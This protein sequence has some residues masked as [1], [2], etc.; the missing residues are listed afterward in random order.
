MKAAPIWLACA[1]ATCGITNA[2]VASNGFINLAVRDRTVTGSIEIAVRDAELAVG[3][4][5]NNDGRVTW[6]ELRHAAPALAQYVQ[7]HFR[8]SA[9]SSACNVQAGALQVNRRVDGPYAWL[10]LEARCPREVR[11]I[12]L[13]YDLLRDVDPSHRGLLTLTSGTTVQTAVLGAVGPVTLEIGRTSRGRAIRE[14]FQE[15]VWHIWRGYDHLLFLVSL[16]LPAVLLRRQKRWEAVDAAYPAF[17]SIL[18]VVTAFTLAHSV[19]LSLAAFGVVRLPSRLTESVIAASI[20]LAAL[21]NI[22]P[23]VTDARARIAFGF[24]LLHGFGFASVLGE[25]GLSRDARLLSLVAFNGGIEVGQ[26]AVV[27]SLMP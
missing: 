11:D 7:E 10:E 20:V 13:A 24:G 9:G 12:T 25:M 2:H 23:V 1:L 5:S 14:Y 3:V 26:L 19:T 22:V 6:G 16:L 27:I 17:L 4:D 15:G 18:K 8:L 21:N